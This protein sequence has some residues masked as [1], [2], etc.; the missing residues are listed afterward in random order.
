MK[1]IL[2]TV[3]VF[4][5]FSCASITPYEPQSKPD[6]LV[7]GKIRMENTNFPVHGS[8][9]VNG[10][11]T[12][13]IEV[14]I[15]N[16]ATGEIKKTNTDKNGF[17]MFYNLDPADNYKIYKIY[18]KI[19]KG[20]SWADVNMHTSTNYIF[21]SKNNSLTDIGMFVLEADK[22]HNVWIFSNTESSI[23]NEFAKKYKNSRWIKKK[24]N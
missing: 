7:V 16:M 3:S 10:I 6:S 15:S 21:S 1:Y 14:S 11:Q 24:S 22:I 18:F 20:T 5:F 9:S 19:E 2:V 8:V 13:N 23:F 12:K 4:I 17:F